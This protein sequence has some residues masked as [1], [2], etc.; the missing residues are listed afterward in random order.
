MVAAA[1]AGSKAKPR[2]YL[3]AGWWVALLLLL[4]IVAFWPVYIVRLPFEAELYVNL[5]V[6]GVVIWMLLLIAQPW[7]IGRGRRPLHKRIGRLSYVLVPWIAVTSVVLAHSRT[8]ALSEADFRTFGHSIYLPFG[9]VLTFVVAWTLAM[10]NR[11]DPF[12]HGRYMV[13]TAFALFDP[14]AAR[15]LFFYSGLPPDENIYPLIGFASADLVL[16]LLL[17]LDRKEPRGR[18]VWLVLLPIYLAVHIG[19]FTIAR[20]DGW[21]TFAQWFV[22][23]PLS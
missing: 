22:A 14:I 5:H 7:L 18:R 19:W 4:A 10:A 2:L 8:A 9:A 17:W 20:S 21:F 15:L 16:L 6:A 1:A 12:L 23:L 11:R 3:T 13:G